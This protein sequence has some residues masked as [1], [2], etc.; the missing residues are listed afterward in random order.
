M[1]A[2]PVAMAA[3]KPLDTYHHGDLRNALLQAAQAQLAKDGPAG[4]S[5]RGLA[6]AAGVSHTAPYRHF[7]N[8]DALL[9]AL[10]AHGLARLRDAMRS[11]VAAV[12]HGPEEQLA[13]AGT[14]YVRL[15]VQQPALAR[16][17]FGDVA[18]AAALAA[19]GETAPAE[20]ERIIVRGIEAGVFRQR[21]VQELVTV[22]W[23]AMHGL[24]MLVTSGM[25]QTDPDDP[26]ALETLV[27][28]LLKN[29][30]YGIMR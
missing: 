8:R 17:M 25:L 24:A 7:R 1:N 20:L 23:T 2:Y 28:T 10:R 16:L 30:I 22:A 14:A 18:G 19:S 11:A 3:D 29:V 13:A 4:L 15:G 6:R 21:D 27:G 5:L 12:P 9:Q 26:Q